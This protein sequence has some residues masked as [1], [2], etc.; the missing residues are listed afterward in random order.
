M[1][2]AILISGRICRYEVCLLPI[3]EKEKYEIDLFVS[4]NDEFCDYYDEMKK[5]LSPWLKGLYVKPYKFPD[6]FENNHIR[7]LR[8]VIDGKY[9]PFNTMSMFFNDMTAFNM[10]T[11]YADDNNFEYD[12]YMK[13]RSDIIVDNFPDIIKTDEIKIFSSKK[14]MTE[15]LIDRKNKTFIHHVPIICDAVAYGNRKTMS[16]YCNTYN[17]VLEVN[18]EW[19]G[20]YP[21]NFEQC[22]THQIYDKEISIDRFEYFYMLDRNRRLFDKYE[23]YHNLGNGI[24]GDKEY[25]QNIQGSSPGIDVKST[26]S[27]SNIPPSGVI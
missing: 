24:G 3:L 16:V 15:A 9:L 22:V 18:N 5:E 7:S 2:I 21:I 1:R 8:Q 19:D 26:K 14:D 23:S 10:A 13:Y 12:A 27:T 11:Q 4:V 17:F 6:G 20:N 25:R